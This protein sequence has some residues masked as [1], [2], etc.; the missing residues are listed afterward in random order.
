MARVFRCRGHDASEVDYDLL[1]L[2]VTAEARHWLGVRS[3]RAA[4]QGLMKLVW[5]LQE[6]RS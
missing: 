1:C 4:K 3:V 6:A 5:L 2:F